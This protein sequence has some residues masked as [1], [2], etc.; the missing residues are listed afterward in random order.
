VGSNPTLSVFQDF[1]RK[2][3]KVHQDKLA[4]LTPY[5]SE[6]LE[7]A[8]N[9]S[10]SL[11]LGVCVT[12]DLRDL[13]ICFCYNDIKFDTILKLQTAHLIYVR[14]ERSPNCCFEPHI[15]YCG[16]ILSCPKR[17]LP[18]KLVRSEDFSPRMMRTKVLT[19]NTFYYGN[20]TGMR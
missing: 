11:L 13:T 1:W 18:I 12:T 20:T 8:N 6:D 2:I 19:T 14:K 10:T 16:R 5:F 17:T 4:Y 15:Q 9:S 7:K 3:C